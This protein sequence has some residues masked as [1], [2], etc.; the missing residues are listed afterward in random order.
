MYR[1]ASD[2]LVARL[3]RPYARSRWCLLCRYFQGW[4]RY[5]RVSPLR[6]Y[7]ICHQETGRFEIPFPRGLV[8]DYYLTVLFIMFTNVNLNVYREKLLTFELRKT[9]EMVMT[10]ELILLLNICKNLPYRILCVDA[11][12]RSGGGRD[13]SRSYSPSGG[14]GGGKT[15]GSRGSP[16]Y[17]PVRRGGGG[18]GSYSR[19]RSRSPRSR[20]RS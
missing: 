2:R 13:R 14:G 19:S 7:E 15:R 9:A 20:S 10:L 4:N 11:A 8:Q 5:G 12:G 6:G 16:S 1:T 3:E 18:G 17:S